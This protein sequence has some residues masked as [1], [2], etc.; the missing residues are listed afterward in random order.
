MCE[1]KTEGGAVTKHVVSWAKYILIHLY[2]CWKVT[3]FSIRCSGLVCP[4]PA[5]PVSA[6]VEQGDVV[7][8]WCLRLGLTRFDEPPNVTVD[9]RSWRVLH[10]SG[11]ERRPIPQLLRCS[12][13]GSPLSYSEKDNTI[14]LCRDL[15][16]AL[17][18]TACQLMQW[19]IQMTSFVSSALTQLL[20]TGEFDSIKT[21][22]KFADMLVWISED[23]ILI[24]YR[25]TTSPIAAHRDAHTH[26][27]RAQIHK[28]R[29]GWN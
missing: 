21:K 12:P 26:V 18:L 16:R 10:G 1:S 7:E 29:E 28:C 24:T 9:S 23:I 6:L 15:P 19:G 5:L 27:M 3:S 2:I 11:W 22:K 17:R 4:H 14:S 25:P 20:S 13:Q 8:V